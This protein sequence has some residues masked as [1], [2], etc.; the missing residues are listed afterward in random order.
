VPKIRIS[1]V[2]GPVSLYAVI[3]R[4]ETSFF[5]CDSDKV[6]AKERVILLVTNK[7]KTNAELLRV[8]ITL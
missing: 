2:V 4:T 7:K 5:Y 8:A 3:V 1:G 6:I